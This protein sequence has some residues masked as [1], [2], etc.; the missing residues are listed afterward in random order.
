MKNLYKKLCDFIH[1]NKNLIIAGMLGF[2][3][4][5][6]F[7]FITHTPYMRMHKMDE[8]YE[9]GRHNYEKGEGRSAGYLP[10]DNPNDGSMPIGEG[11]RMG[12][13]VGITTAPV[14][15][16]TPEKFS[17][18]LKE[19]NTGC[20]SDGECYVVVDDKGAMKHVTIA[21]GWTQATVGRIIGTDSMGNMEKFIGKNI[22]LS[23]S[24]LDADNYTLY[25][26]ADYFIDVTQK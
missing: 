2:V 8:R 5:Y 3:L 16:G 21:L 25:G 15:I 13:P 12:Y 6:G 10:G 19:V 18:I 23:V 14:S 24:K 20:F 26:N 4:G 9:G 1:K 7:F 17:G 22:N 11:R